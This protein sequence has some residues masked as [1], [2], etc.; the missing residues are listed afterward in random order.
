[1][2]QVLFI[3]IIIGFL[4]SCKP[5]PKVVPISS[6]NSTNQ[7]ERLQLDTLITESTE[8]PSEVIGEN[9]M[10][11]DRWKTY[12]YRDE[13]WLTEK[14]QY[15][16]SEQWTWKYYNEM[17][18]E[19]DVR[20]QGEMSVYVD[21]VSGTI[22]LE[23]NATLYSDDMTDWVIVSP[24]GTY[25]MGYTGEHGS[26]TRVKLH[27]EDNIDLKTQLSG[28]EEDFNNYVKKTGEFEIFGQHQ[29]G[30]HTM[31]GEEYLMTYA[32]TTDTNYLNITSVP[33]NM[34]PFYYV[35]KVNQDLSMPIKMHYG[36]ILEDNMLVLKDEYQYQSQKIGFELQHMS[37]TTYFLDINGYSE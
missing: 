2:S 23:R 27:L 10:V 19:D 36:H 11:S 32:K 17:V 16:F 37:P 31:H 7:E 28:R 33:F 9:E 20:R 18:P 25:I 15:F 3:I 6:E 30:W 22:L 12:P 8:D 4:S 14:G 13:N 34:R 29:P 5:E 24:D 21:P 1:M 26:K 35:D